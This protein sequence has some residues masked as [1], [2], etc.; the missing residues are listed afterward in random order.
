MFL[1]FAYLYE[2]QISDKFM[3]KPKFFISTTFSEA[4]EMKSQVEQYILGYNFEPVTFKKEALKYN[5]SNDLNNCY[6]II[7]DSSFFI[8]LIEK[9]I[10]SHLKSSQTLQLMDS[11]TELE[12]NI[13]KRIGIPIFVFIQQHSFDEYT[14]YSNSERKDEFKFKELGSSYIANF[15]STI[16]Q[17]KPY[18]YV[19]QYNNIA[20]IK[21]ELKRQWTGLFHKYLR[22]S[23]SQDKESNEYVVV[24]PFKLFYFRNLLG[25][26]IRRIATITSIPINKIRK[27]EDSGKRR[28]KDNLYKFKKIKLVHLQKIAEILQ[29]NVANLKAGLPDD[30]IAQYVSYYYKHKLAEQKFE[31][32]ANNLFKVKAIV[33]DF[34]GTLTISDQGHS[35]WVKL[36]LALGYDEK[37][38][39]DLHNK[40]TSGELTHKKWCQLTCD[41]FKERG[42]S[43]T[44]LDLVSDEINLIADCETCISTLVE[45]G[46]KVYIC[47]GSIDYIINR[48]L[49]GI[50]HKFTEI[51]CNKF[52]F[53]DELLSSIVGTKFDFEGKSHY[54]TQVAKDL[55]IRPYEILFVGNSSND[56]FAWQAGAMT[57]CI[58]PI[59]ANHESTYI[60]NH[61]IKDLKD[62]TEILDLID[63]SYK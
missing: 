35:T 59:N 63:F 24:N 32:T 14:T 37:T 12:F 9:D 42:L 10:E 29:C 54:I 17:D 43:K 33:F 48:V 30:Y 19:F 36:W 49:R 34:D 5:H 3:S 46:K 15:F 44:H 1:D 62:L 26:P 38:C 22:D 53:E 39:T 40:F 52:K 13:A 28:G 27:L 2:I 51:K 55:K 50:K 18:I 47:S 45:K 23:K 31:I 61:F 6:E 11:F 7:K 60:W 41:L 25:I 56:E 58:N 8:L 16:K 21:A 20:D 4:N 57:L